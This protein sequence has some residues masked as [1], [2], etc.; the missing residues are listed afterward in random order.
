LE[1]KMRAG[2]KWCEISP[3][4]LKFY[5]LD[6]G[7][8]GEGVD[9][10]EEGEGACEREERKNIEKKEVEVTT[11]REKLRYASFDH[12]GTPV[13][14]RNTN[15]DHFDIKEGEKD[16]TWQEERGIERRAHRATSRSTGFRKIPASRWSMD[17]ESSDIREEEGQRNDAWY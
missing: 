14:I 13:Y 10:G 12:F 4:V 3:S 1:E 2:M 7:E 5:G 6:E 9:E 16:C 8:E 17:D 15:Q 11:S